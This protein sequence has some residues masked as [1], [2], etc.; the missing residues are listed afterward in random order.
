M[1]A[2]F[3]ICTFIIFNFTVNDDL[4]LVLPY[5]RPYRHHDSSLI[6]LYYTKYTQDFDLAE[7]YRIFGYPD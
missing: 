6:Y 1:A 7:I 2:N 5:P 3:K 4:S